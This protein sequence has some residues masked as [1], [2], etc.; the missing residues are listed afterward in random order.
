LGLQISGNYL[1]HFFHQKVMP[2]FHMNW[3][4]HP[5]SPNYFVKFLIVILFDLTLWSIHVSA[6][7]PNVDL[8]LFTEVIGISSWIIM[9]FGYL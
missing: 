9:N 5:K 1:Y 6:W 3:W 7:L 8:I 2:T 4:H